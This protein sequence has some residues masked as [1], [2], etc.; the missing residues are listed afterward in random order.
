VS[1]PVRFL[2]L[3]V[4]GW[5]GLRAASLGM[6][7]GGKLLWID[8][9]EAAPAPPVQATEFPPIDPVGA[10]FIP[11]GFQMPQAQFAQQQAPIAIPVYY[12][13]ASV[14]SPR[15]RA[16]TPLLPEPRPLFY[17]PVPQLDDWPL[18]RLASASMPLHR[19]AT[20]V[21]QQSSPPEIV[22]QKLDRAQLSMWAL[23][24]GRPGPS[25]LS[26][27]G[28]LGGSQAGARLTYAFDRR[29]ALSL[30]SYTPVGGSGGE[31]AGGVR[32][33]PFASIPIA[34]TAERRQRINRFG[35]RSAFAL[36][37]EGGVYQKPMPGRFLLDA[38]AQ[39]GI[40]G[41][42]HRDLFVD[43]GFTL[44]RPVWRQYSAGL[45][46]WGGYQPDLYRVDAGPRLTM[47]VRNNMRVHADWRQKL[48][49][50]AQ[51]GSG[52]VLTLAGDF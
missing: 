28:S 46:V 32:I 40:V 14:P 52:P 10:D 11:A 33:T 38:Y 44:T 9:S 37:L 25:S 30:R 16:L 51:P 39:A 36:F 49:G 26:G 13:P 4:V 35:G 23:L 2:A 47:R 29:L 18:S 20:T 17:S 50:N 34:L 45:G 7:P 41:A 1:A 27:T 15:R 43:G 22:K 8:R 24:R 42:R 3:V 19:S 48:A 6:I 5:A 12:Y 31:F 21:P